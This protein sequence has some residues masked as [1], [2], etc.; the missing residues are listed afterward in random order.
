[1]KYEGKELPYS[2]HHDRLQTIDQGQVVNNKR[3][4][5]VIAFIIEKQAELNKKR[6]KTVL[7][8]GLRKLIQVLSKVAD[9]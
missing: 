7:N 4:G 1:M 3:L 9:D 6:S 5:D 2:I 8:G